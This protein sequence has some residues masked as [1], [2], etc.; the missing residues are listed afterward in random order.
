MRL[1]GLY[2]VAKAAI[3]KLDDPFVRRYE[4]AI[5]LGSL[6]EDVWYLPFGIIYEHLSFSHFGKPPLPG[7]F[8]PLVY[9]GPRWKGRIFYR[10]AV[11]HA[12]RG[13]HAKAFVQ[14]GRVV[15]LLTDMSCPVHVHRTAHLTDPFEWHVEGNKRRLLALPVPEVGEF[16]DVAALLTSMARVTSRHPPDATNW[17]PG[18]LLR[19]LGLRKA[20]D[21]RTAKQQAD[22]LIPI[23]A[24]HTVSLLRMYLRDIDSTAAMQSAAG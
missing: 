9:P 1:N 16:P 5:V 21:A 4:A 2:V 3:D 24:G 11:A 17:P 7:G 22:E 12:R 10:R 18:R 6:R 14:L 13:D 8:L 23:C 19:K 20:I 15:H